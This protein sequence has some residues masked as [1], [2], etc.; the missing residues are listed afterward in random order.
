MEEVTISSE[1]NSLVNKICSAEKKALILML[2][3]T[4]LGEDIEFLKKINRLTFGLTKGF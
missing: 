4:D 2:L 3:A 1:T